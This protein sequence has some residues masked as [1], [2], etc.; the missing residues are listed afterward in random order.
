MYDITLSIEHARVIRD[1]L[2]IY[3][4]RWPGGHPAEQE[5]IM[6]LETEFN[7]MILE[8]YLDA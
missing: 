8:S 3:K 6:F 7:K 4:E 5:M 2:V 1:A